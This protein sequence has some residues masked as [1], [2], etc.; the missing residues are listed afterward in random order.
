MGV[1][2]YLHS[3]DVLEVDCPQGSGTG[4][5]MK[6][7]LC[8]AVSDAHGK[9]MFKSLP[10]G[11]LYIFCFVLFYTVSVHFFSLLAFSLVL[12]FFMFRTYL[13]GY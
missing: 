7:A 5:E 13:V 9:F 4:S 2:V 10:C 3:D 12:L 11:N 1:H 6:K 8:H